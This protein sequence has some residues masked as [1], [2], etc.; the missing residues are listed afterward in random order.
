MHQLILQTWYSHCLG[1]FE[2]LCFFYFV[3]CWCQSVRAFGELKGRK[4]NV[5]SRQ[6]NTYTQ[7]ITGHQVTYVLRSFNASGCHICNTNPHKHTRAVLVRIFIFAFCVLRWLIF[8]A[9]N[10]DMGA[11][12]GWDA[13][14]MKN[15][16]DGT[17]ILQRTPS[18]VAK[19][20]QKQHHHYHF[21]STKSTVFTHWNGNDKN[22]KY[23]LGII[24]EN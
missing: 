4:Q 19:Q 13:L 20:Q 8:R 6:W 16:T 2:F 21:A 18:T 5:L 9:L 3:F 12:N 17:G 7:F 22:E 23:H 11:R 1:A 24:Y 15:N 10:C 14:K